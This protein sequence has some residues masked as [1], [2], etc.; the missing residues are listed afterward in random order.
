VA[1]KYAKATG[2]VCSLCKGR[3]KENEKKN[4]STFIVK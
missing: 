1:K 2:A 3:G 4:L